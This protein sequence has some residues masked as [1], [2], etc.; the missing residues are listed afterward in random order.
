MKIHFTIIILILFLSGCGGNDD[1]S[2]KVLTGAIYYTWYNS[3][4]GSKWD[5]GYISEPF[6]GF[7]SSRDSYVIDKHLTWAKA[8]GIDYFMIDWWNPHDYLE[9]TTLYYLLNSQEMNEF[10][11]AIMY[12]SDSH[13][14]RNP[15]FTID[16][17]D[18][19]MDRFLEDIYYIADTYFSHPNYLKIDGRPV[20]YLYQAS[21]YIENI[22]EAMTSMRSVINSLGHN[23]YVIGDLVTYWQSP[24]WELNRFRAA[25]FDAISAYTMF[26]DK[27]DIDVNWEQEV[28]NR[29]YQWYLMAD[30]V[31]VSFIPT[32]MPGYNDTAVRPEANHPVIPRTTE[33]FKKLCEASFSFAK[34]NNNMLLITSW[35]EWHE[36]TQVEPDK[37]DY[38]YLKVI[39]DCVGDGAQQPQ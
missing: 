13:L 16:F 18:V 37:N 20:I 22:A 25:Q 8:A 1:S 14:R 12:N 29:Y 3:G 39:K 9:D 11:F 30:E 35:N 2:K 6:L 5:E 4:D 32:I 27:P 28:M 34:E 7:Y 38:E 21:A 17:D 26:Y 23:A 10:Q 15:D 31:G 33:G 24:Q 19:N 36:H